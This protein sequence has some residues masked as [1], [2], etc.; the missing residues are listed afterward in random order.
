MDE[1]KHEGLLAK[2]FDKKKHY[3]ELVKWWKHHDHTQ[4]HPSCLPTTGVV[5][6]NK[7]G[8]IILASF[9]Y[10]TDSLCA[11]IDWTTANPAARPAVVHSATGIAVDYLFELAKHEG[12][13]V[14]WAIS[15]SRGLAKAM[16]RKGFKQSQKPHTILFKE[17]NHGT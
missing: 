6:M 8:L 12:V 15:G 17:T 16:N 2:P 11:I 7:D 10:F 4:L 5:V 14:V 3:P 9:L 1:K 13:S